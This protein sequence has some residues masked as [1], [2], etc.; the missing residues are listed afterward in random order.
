MNR[1]WIA[2]S[3][4]IMATC[5]AIGIL[6]IFIASFNY[7][8]LWPLFTIFVHSIALLFPMMCDGY[9][10]EG[11]D[12]GFPD[13]SSDLFLHDCQLFGWFLMAVFF[14]SGYALPIILYHSGII[15]EVVIYLVISGGTCIWLSIILF[16]HLFCCGKQNF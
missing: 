3:I 14:I 13:D 1:K 4:L 15:P 2:I 12:F 5:L 16:I 8:N 11:G 9:D 6:L 10:I 7:N